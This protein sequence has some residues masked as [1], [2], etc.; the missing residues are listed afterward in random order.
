MQAVSRDTYPD[1]VLVASHTRPVL[2][3]FWGPRCGPCVAMM[4]WVESLAALRDGLEEFVERA[5]VKG[6]DDVRTA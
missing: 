2:V 1:D 4:P 5:R 3:D 6:G